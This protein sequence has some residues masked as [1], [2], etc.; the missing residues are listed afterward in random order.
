[1]VE[2]NDVKALSR[3]LRYADGEP[4]GAEWLAAGARETG[5]NPADLAGFRKAIRRCD[6]G[7]GMSFSAEW[8][9]LREPYDRRAR[10]AAVM[11]R[12]D[13]AAQGQAVA[14]KSSIWLAGQARTC[15]PLSPRIK[16]RQSWRHW[17]TTI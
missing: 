9:A 12:R 15:A 6:R 17:S 8:L 4:Q 7:R 3:T 5:Q 11:G 2:P 1:L 14:A 16:A 13:N 10:N